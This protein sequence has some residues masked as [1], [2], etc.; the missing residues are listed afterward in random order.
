MSYFIHL[1]FDGPAF[2]MKPRI[3]A[4]HSEPNISSLQYKLYSA[5]IKVPYEPFVGLLLC[6]IYDASLENFII[7]ALIPSFKF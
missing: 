5:I 2:V 1:L 7:N 6:N 3:P 4:H